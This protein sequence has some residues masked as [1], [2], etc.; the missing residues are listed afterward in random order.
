[1]RSTSA[2]RKHWG[3]WSY[4]KRDIVTPCPDKLLQGISHKNI[5][6]KKQVVL[7]QQH[8]SEIFMCRKTWISRKISDP[9]DRN[10]ENKNKGAI[11]VERIRTRCHLQ[12]TIQNCLSRERQSHKNP[13]KFFEVNPKAK[14]YTKLKK[15]DKRRGKKKRKAVLQRERDLSQMM[16]WGGLREGSEC[17]TL[18]YPKHGANPDVL[19]PVFSFAPTHIYKFLPPI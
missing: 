1:M 19:L 3:W 15:T 13:V 5:H 18:E 16:R 7:M 11:Q 4:G 14:R 17:A 9:W 12:R 10:Q 2:K 6:T 8:L